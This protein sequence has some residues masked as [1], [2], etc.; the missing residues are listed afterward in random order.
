MNIPVP[1]ERLNPKHLKIESF[2]SGGL[3]RRWAAVAVASMMGRVPHSGA[4]CRMRCSAVASRAVRLIRTEFFDPAFSI[5]VFGATARYVSED[6]ILRSQ[7]AG[8][9]KFDNN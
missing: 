1:D 5:L 9:K 3:S 2:S 6:V 7:Q 8:P 4:A